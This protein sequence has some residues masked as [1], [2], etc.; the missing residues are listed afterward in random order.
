M[1]VRCAVLLMLL[2]TLVT[3]SVSQEIT[4]NIVGTVSDSTGAAIP[5]ATV[6]VKNTNTNIVKTYTTDDQGR[7][8]ATLLPIGRYSVTVEAKGFQ[9]YVKAN[10]ELNV[11][12]RLTISPQLRVGSSEQVIEVQAEAT[13]VD[14]QSAA[15]TGLVTGTQVRELSLNNRNYEQLLTLVPG[16]TSTASDQIYVGATNP[17]GTNTVNFS[18]NGGRTSQNNW[19]VDGADNVDRGSNLTLLSFPSVDAIAEFSLVRGAYDPEFGR[20]AG[21]QINVVTRSGT[22]SFHGSAYEFLRNDK[23]NANTYLNKN[24][25]VPTPRNPLRYNDFGWTFGGPIYIPGRYNTQKNRTFFFFSQEFRRVITYTS[26]LATVANANERTGIFAHPVCTAW[27]GTTCTAT[28]T[29]IPQSAWSVTAGNYLKDIYSKIPVPDPITHQFLSQYRALNNFREE[30][31]KVDQNFGSKLSISA[32]LLW[33]SIPSEEPGGLFTGSPIA[34]V[35]G[36]KTNS[37]G[38]NFTFRGTYTITPT[39]LLDAGYAYSYGAILSD[40]TGSIARSASPNINPTLPYTPT[41]ARVPTVTMTGLSSLTGFGPY[42]DY[43]R[44]HSVFGNVS[45]VTGRHNIKAGAIYYHYQKTENAGGNN[46]GTFAFDTSGNPCP[47][48]STAGC[49]GVATSS[50]E[51]SWANFLLGHVSSFTQ[52][53]YDLTPDIRDNQF[54]FYGQDKIA[55]KSNLTLTVGFRWSFF[56]QPTDASGRLTNFD[57]ATYD[58]SKAPCFTPAGLINLGAPCNANWDP[59][60]GIIIAGQNSPYGSKV[61]SEDNRAIAPRVGIA[62]DPFKNGKTS[63]RAGFGMF[64]DTTLFG[65]VEQNIFANPPFVNSPN[66]PNTSFDNPAGGTASVNASPKRVYSRVPVNLKTPYT[67]QWSLDF[68]QE[69][70]PSLMIDVGYYGSVGRHLIGILDINQPQPGVYKTEVATCSAT[71]TTNCVPANGFITTSNISLI[72][73]IRPYP[74]YVGIDGIRPW[75]DSNYNSLQVQLQKKFSHDSLFNVAYTWSHALTNNQTDRSTAPQNSYN[76]QGDYGPM[77]QDRRHVITGNYVYYLPWFADQKG[78]AGHILGGWELSGIITAQSGVPLT[79]GTASTTNDFAG[80]GCR[81]PSPCAVR[82]DQIGDPN[83]NA[84]HTFAKWFDTSVFVNPPAGQYRPGNSRRGT[85]LGPGLWRVDFSVFK[86][87]KITERVNTQFR[88]ETFNLFNHT[89]FNDV[90]TST[91]SP[92]FGAI[93][94]TRDPRQIQLG[95]KLSF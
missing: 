36:T 65:T 34:G 46:V 78:L 32:K 83:A 44:N 25:A 38:H 27:S 53:Q 64:Y 28:G 37:P 91:T 45:K 31:L 29:T 9:K 48:A 50:F 7:Y 66:I 17:L 68:Q 11:N 70:T 58:P 33:D 93:T 62:W 40:I 67:E 63:I 18:V 30:M 5:G 61:G 79:I 52:D 75:F 74:G 77:Q 22:S 39:L 54:E 21:G 47:T 90:N 43:N 55:L 6:I 85:I 49:N 23:L 56:R 69:L 41:L 24:K 92:T 76:F 81:G 26:Q 95:L 15:A 2:C 20:N 71:V 57:P 35:S 73:P 72:N 94:S 80:Q 59:L 60:N 8:V 10:I 1:R 13:Q 4:G 19:M 3:L 14:T 82:P 12:D 51:Q 89:N 87:I 42:R 88:A 86:N 16:V 84:P